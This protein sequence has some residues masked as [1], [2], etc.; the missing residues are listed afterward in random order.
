MQHITYN[1]CVAIVNFHSRIC[2][3][4]ESENLDLSVDSVSSANQGEVA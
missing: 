1:L 2:T 3:K 4:L